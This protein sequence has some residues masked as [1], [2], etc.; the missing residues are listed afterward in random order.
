M[1][2]EEELSCIRQVLAGDADAF[3][4]LV[5]AYEKQL[6]NLALRM[7]RNEQDAADAAQDAFVRAYTSLADFR[8]DSK[9]SVWLY[10]ICGNICTDRLRKM[11]RHRE[12]P[13]PA[14]TEDGEELTVELPDP[15]P[16]PEELTERR[17]L[18]E[19]VS[20]ALH[21]LPD[22]M[23]EILLLRENAGLSYDELAETLSLEIG[24]VKSRLN[25]ARKKLC[26]KLTEDRNFSYAI[27]S[28]NA[29]EV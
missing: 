15:A 29:K 2:R 3:A 17:E 20:R 19:C 6:Y 14:E 10:R 27:S 25:R 11:Q 23:R 9:F 5:T 7:L 24:T 26:E 21:A 16:G 28:K 4:P 1:T 12:M 8:G 22:D 18:A 13:L